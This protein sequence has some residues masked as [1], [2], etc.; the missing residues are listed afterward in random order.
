MIRAGEASG[1]LDKVLNASLTLLS[2]S[3]TQVE[4]SKRNDVSRIMMV[5]GGVIMLVMLS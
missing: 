1:A 4:D 3:P 5:M 2:T